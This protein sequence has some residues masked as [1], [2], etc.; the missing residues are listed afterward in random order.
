MANISDLIYFDHAAATPVRSELW[1][2]L[3]ELAM[4]CYANP[5]AAHRLASEVRRLL[6]DAGQRLAA[7]V[8]GRTLPECGVV[9]GGSASELLAL[10]GSLHRPAHAA[11][12]GSQ[13][14][15]PAVLA[16]LRRGCGAVRMTEV[17]RD[18]RW[19][20]PATPDGAVAL[21]AVSWV[22]SE[23][24]LIQPLDRMLPELRRAFP[25]ALLLVDAVQGAGKLEFPAALPDLAVV[26]GH[27]FGAP[28][29]AALLLLSPAARQLEK[30]LAKLRRDDYLTGRTEPLNALLL[31]RA[32]EL[33]AA[34]CK[35]NFE[36]VAALGRLLR[37]GLANLELPVGKEVIFTAAEER[38]SPYILHF[39]LPGY[40]SGVLVRM[41]SQRD[42][43]VAA[44]SACRA[45]SKLPSAALTALGFPRRLGHSGLRLSFS[46]ANTVAEAQTF[47]KVLPEVLRDY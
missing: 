18:G 29:G 24:G 5:E 22:Q 44:G 2:L 40:D 8:F 46:P 10:I 31:S 1:P 19:Q 23:T 25:E 47:L 20:L 37:A 4:R 41:L 14:E 45:E 9:F 34:E 39:V 26:S 6:E 3:P 13:L 33:A 30:A 15:H 43:M 7:A 36:R 17:D 11:G 27:K 32:A 28:G 38:S 21:A 12:A 16:M 35:P 42:I